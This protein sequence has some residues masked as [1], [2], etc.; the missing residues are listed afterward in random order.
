MLCDPQ[1]P[2]HTESVTS[3]FQTEQLKSWWE[4]YELDDEEQEVGMT[5]RRGRCG[6]HK[7]PKGW[8]LSLLMLSIVRAKVLP[9]TPLR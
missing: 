6:E 8:G 5:S 4:N 9:K 3:R 7:N 1:R 2:H